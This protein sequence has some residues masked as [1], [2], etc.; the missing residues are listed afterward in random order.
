MTSIFDGKGKL[1]LVKECFICGA[2]KIWVFIYQTN[3]S[4]KKNYLWCWKRC[5]LSLIMFIKSE[6]CDKKIYSESGNESSS[7][8]SL[9][10]SVSSSL[11]SICLFSVLS[12]FKCLYNSSPSRKSL[13]FLLFEAFSTGSSLK[14][15]ICLSTSAWTLHLFLVNTLFDEKVKRAIIQRTD[16]QRDST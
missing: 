5:S 4:R 2:G 3:C 12:R 8:W 9:I 13:R 14:N 16:Q 6:M 1:T 11:Q 15:I 7:S 10:F